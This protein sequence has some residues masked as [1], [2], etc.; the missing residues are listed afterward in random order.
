MLLL[1]DLN[2]YRKCV[3]QWRL[4]ANATRQFESLHALAN[5]LVVLPDNLSD[6]AHSP[7]LV[8]FFSQDRDD[9]RTPF[10]VLTKMILKQLIERSVAQTYAS[11]AIVIYCTQTRVKNRPPTAE[12]KKVR[13][14]GIIIM[15]ILSLEEH[16]YSV[17]AGIRQSGLNNFQ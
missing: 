7:M 5:L 14:S 10:N 15:Q 16:V 8:C 2:E 1:C 11:E 13:S 3:S 4:E 12:S 17:L 6:A 9:C